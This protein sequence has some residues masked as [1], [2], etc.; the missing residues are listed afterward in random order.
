MSML[1]YAR[2]ISTIALRFLFSKLTSRPFVPGWKLTTLHIIAIGAM[3][4]VW[5]W[6]ALIGTPTRDAKGEVRVGD[7]LAGKGLIELGWD[8]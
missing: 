2:Q 8:L 7:D 4:V 5:R 6:F 1:A 3:V